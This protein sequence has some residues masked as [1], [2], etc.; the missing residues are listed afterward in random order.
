MLTKPDV[1]DVF[2]EIEVCVAYRHKGETLKSFP[3][4]TWELAEVEPRFKKIKGWRKPVFGI[5]DWDSLPQAF[6]DYVKLI[7]DLIQAE[8][9]IIS[10]G[11]DRKESILIEE[12]LKSWV[13]LEK[14]KAEL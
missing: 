11:K 10:T 1:L 8:V 2:D 13:N 12:Y 4:D 6:V 3:S 14:I 7:E 5:K 9:A